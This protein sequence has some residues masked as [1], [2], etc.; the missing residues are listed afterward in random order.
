MLVKLVG[1]N[2][3]YFKRLFTK[4]LKIQTE[5]KTNTFLKDLYKGWCV[6]DGFFFPLQK[7]FLCQFHLVGFLFFL[8]FFFILSL[9]CWLLWPM[10]K[11]A[12]TSNYGKN[13]WFLLSN[14]VPFCMYIV[15]YLC[16]IFV[17]MHSIFALPGWRH[18]C[19]LK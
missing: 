9:F 12:F 2:K 1:V 19:S 18:E 10:H 8:T 5:R 15:V 7:D 14:Y 17:C 3:N 13:L 6:A 4:S 11:P 16:I